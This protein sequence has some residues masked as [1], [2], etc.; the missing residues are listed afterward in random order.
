MLCYFKEGKSTTEIQSK[1]LCHVWRRCCD[2]SNVSEVAHEIPCLR[3]LMDDA[4]WLNRSVE[5]ETNQIKTLTESHQQYPT[6]EIVNILK[7]SKSSV[8]NHLHQL[9]VKWRSEVKSL[10]HVRLFVTPWTVAYQA[11]PSMGFSRQEYWSGLP[12]PSPGDLPKPG[13]EPVSSALQTDTLPS[14]P[15]GKP[16]TS[17]VMLITVM[18]GS[19]IS[20]CMCA[21][22]FSRVQLFET[23]WTVSCQAPLSLEFSRQ[24][25]WSEWPFPSPGDLP[26]PGIEPMSWPYFHTWF[27]TEM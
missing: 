17:L 10:S 11:P 25:Y 21:Q 5:A 2:W 4:P 13:I 7:I 26:D 3:F 20:V 14:E 19:H 24:E 16:C 27:P 22:L 12:F 1:S 18:F 9:E 23:S 8:E 15:P 6:W